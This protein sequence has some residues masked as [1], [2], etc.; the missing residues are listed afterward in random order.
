MILMPLERNYR[1]GRAIEESV[2]KGVAIGREKLYMER[3]FFAEKR[4]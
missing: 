3:S 1:C 2:V 4:S